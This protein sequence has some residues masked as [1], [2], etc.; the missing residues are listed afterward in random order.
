MTQNKA[1]ILNVFEGLSQSP[2]I[3]PIEL[4]AHLLKTKLKLK[5]L[6]NKQQL[7]A[8]TLNDEQSSSREETRHSELTLGSRA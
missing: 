8:D 7:K 4:A 6:K 1:K 3:N 5:R 2:D